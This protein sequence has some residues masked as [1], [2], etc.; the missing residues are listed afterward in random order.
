MASMAGSVTCS[1]RSADLVRAFFTWG[2]GGYFIP[3]VSRLLR[4]L[5]G[6]IGRVVSVG[7]TQG[8]EATFKAHLLSSRC[9]DFYSVAFGTNILLAIATASVFTII[10]TTSLSVIHFILTNYLLL[11]MYGTALGLDG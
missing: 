1:Y 9:V 8:F 4:L 7:L 6:L 11:F 2:K 3:F 10:V 5:L